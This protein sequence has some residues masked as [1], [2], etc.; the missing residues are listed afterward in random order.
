V[1]VCTTRFNVRKRDSLV[2]QA[3]HVKRM[4]LRANSGSSASVTNQLVFVMGTH[5]FLRVLCAFTASN[6]ECLIEQDLEASG[7]GLFR[8]LLQ[9]LRKFTQKIE[10]QL[11]SWQVFGPSTTRI[12]VW[13]VT[14][15]PTFS[16]F[17]QRKKLCGL[18]PQANYT[19]LT[20]A[21]CRRS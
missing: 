8:K 6:D 19:D 12:W 11:V 13:S 10:G 16:Q 21:D 14:A 1:P 15:I 5:W 3:M 9:R 4:T 2:S 18:S 20:T 17:L 7:H